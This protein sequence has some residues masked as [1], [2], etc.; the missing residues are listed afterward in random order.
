M[1]SA[2]AVSIAGDEYRLF[3]VPT[4]CSP[5][6]DDWQL[7]HHSN[8]GEGVT[9]RDSLPGELLHMLSVYFKVHP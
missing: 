4:S 7:H 1:Q 5:S 9:P 6:S 2:L 8:D 3:L